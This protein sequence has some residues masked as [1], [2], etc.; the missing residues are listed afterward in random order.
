MSVTVKVTMKS[1]SIVRGMMT[2]TKGATVGERI[3]TVTLLMK[4]LKLPKPTPATLYGGVHVIRRNHSG[5]SGR[6]SNC[7]TT[8]RHKCL[9]LRCHIAAQGRLA[10]ARELWRLWNHGRLVPS[11]DSAVYETTRTLAHTSLTLTPTPLYILLLHCDQYTHHENTKLQYTD[12][13]SCN[14]LLKPTPADKRDGDD[15]LGSDPYKDNDEF[16]EHHHCLCSHP[17]H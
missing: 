7:Q 15:E 10:G 3:N 12:C 14:V 5:S 17:H 1:G 11:H 6:S 2:G 16:L 4:N 9:H 13:T 8:F